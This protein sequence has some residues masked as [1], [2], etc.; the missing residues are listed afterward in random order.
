MGVKMNVSMAAC[1]GNTFIGM[2]R[3]KKMISFYGQIPY[4]A[5]GEFSCEIQVFHGMPGILH[6]HWSG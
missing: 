3:T 4:I 1:A 5:I 6:L 2:N